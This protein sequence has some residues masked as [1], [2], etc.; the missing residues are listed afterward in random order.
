MWPHYIYGLTELMKMH[1][2]TEQEA[3]EIIT[4][5]TCLYQSSLNRLKNIYEPALFIFDRCLLHLT[6]NLFEFPQLS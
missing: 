1:M 5:I 2:C 3:V 4:I 6:V